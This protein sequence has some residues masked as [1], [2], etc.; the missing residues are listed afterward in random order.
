MLCD[1]EEKPGKACA[2]PFFAWQCITLQIQGRAVDLVIKD[3]NDM[4]VFLRFL[5]QAL[6]TVDGTANSAQFYIEAAALNEVARREKALNKK[7]LARR[8][9]IRLRGDE[10]YDQSLQLLQ[11]SQAEKDRIL[12][13]KRREI[14]RQTMFKFTLMK[15]RSKISYYAFRRSMP[16]AE[17]MLT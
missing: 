6:N 9:S 3:E 17:L 15:V 13:E 10:E 12:E 4:N 2:F 11:L 14:H 8:K 1:T 16:I 7:I 5:V